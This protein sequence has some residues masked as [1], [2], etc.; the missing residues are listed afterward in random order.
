MELEESMI[1]EVENNELEQG[2]AAEAKALEPER[3]EVPGVGEVL[4][5]GCP[6]EVED[7]LDDHQGDNFLNAGGDCGVVSVVNIARLFGVNCT[8]DD[9]ILKAVQNRLCEYSTANDAADN[10]GTSYLNRQALLAEYGISTTA[11][12]GKRLSPEQIA[13]LAEAGHLVNLSA[14]AGY[15]WGDPDYIDDGSSN[16]SVVV[17]GSARDPETHE[18]VGLFICDSGVPGKSSAVFVPVDVLDRAY[19]RAPG[20]TALVTDRPMSA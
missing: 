16:H 6:F 15:L 11:F 13:R 12:E 17:T 4:V 2:D 3:V 20:S 8:E 10:G 5:G 18:L 1:R 14:N 7:Q 19:T 9:A